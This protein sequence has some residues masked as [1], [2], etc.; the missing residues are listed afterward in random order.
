MYEIIIPIIIPIIFYL[1]TYFL[2]KKR[3]IKKAFMVNLW[4][5]ILLIFFIISGIGGL[6]LSLLLSYNII[7][8]FNNYLLYW[9]VEF[10]IGM[11]I[12]AFIHLKNYWKIILRLFK[13]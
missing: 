2:L 1:I 9:H 11:I 6:I 5:L 13:N 3:F 12:I 10:G 8:P 7:T 4:N